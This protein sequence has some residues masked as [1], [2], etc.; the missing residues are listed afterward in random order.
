MHLP[1]DTL[2]IKHI[3]VI[4]GQKASRER[5]LGPYAR[6]MASLLRVRIPWTGDAITGPGLTTFFQRSNVY[7]PTI[8]SGFFN[9]IKSLVPLGISWT[10]PATQ[11]LIE[12]TTGELVG[13]TSAG[14]TTTVSS[15]V[16]TAYAAGVGARI[17]W[18]TSLIRGGRRV[19][20]S[21]FVCPLL[22]SA[23]DTQGS[24]ASGT[25]TALQSAADTL[26]TALGG[27]MVVWSRPR[28]TLVG[29]GV[30]IAAGVVA[31]KVSWLRSRR[32]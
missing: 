11:D 20:G 1:E 31:D 32:T 19:R 15:T 16:G 2:W 7:D 26:V 3:R 22:T 10:I 23:Y 6:T 12:E 29:A 28:P 25:Q 13:T 24:L 8:Y 9:N 30:P 5:S 27:E 14:T 18:T 21:T 17:A 4:A